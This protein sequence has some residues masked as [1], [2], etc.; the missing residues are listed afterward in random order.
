MPETASWVRGRI[1]AVLDFAK[2]RGLR[3]G[4]NPAAWRGHL[5][6]I[7]TKRQ[8]LSRGHHAAMNF[9][10]V[11]A[12]I[13][14][15]R[16]REAT[17]ALSLEFLILT[18][19]RSG[20]VLGARWSEIDFDKRLRFAHEGR[21]RASRAA[22]KPGAGDSRKARRDA[23]GRI[24]LR[25]PAGRK[26]ALGHGH[27]NDFAPDEGR[28]RDGSWL[29]LFL[30]RLVRRSN[31]FPRDGF[32][33]SKLAGLHIHFFMRTARSPARATSARSSRHPND[34]HEL[35]FF[36]SDHACRRA[37]RTVLHVLNPSAHP[38][39]MRLRSE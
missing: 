25:G 23:N 19:A 10:E 38:S 4:E 27:G 8:K 29:S 30:S 12:F 15:L 17:A 37:R 20:E 36:A 2:A 32:P 22:L 31:F 34:G 6:L 33:A 16:E 13:G 9:D 39:R 5:A 24:R 7:L 28:R 18:A 1:E 35:S 3:S 11:P 14:K 21:A 26:A